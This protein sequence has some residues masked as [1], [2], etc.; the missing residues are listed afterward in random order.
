MQK[1]GLRRKN[2]GGVC[3]RP[4]IPDAAVFSFQRKVTQPKDVSPIDKV[5]V[6]NKCIAR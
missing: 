1:G 3:T 5:F 4:S 2:A 6:Q